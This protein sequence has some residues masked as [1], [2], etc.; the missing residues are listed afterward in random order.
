M[1]PGGKGMLMSKS[2]IRLFKLNSHYLSLTGYT[3]MGLFVKVCMQIT[4]GVSGA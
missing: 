4:N 3:V 2:E 1:P